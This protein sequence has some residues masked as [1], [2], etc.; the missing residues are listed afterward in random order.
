MTPIVATLFPRLSAYEL[1]LTADDPGVSMALEHWP[2]RG[3]GGAVAAVRHVGESPLATV[4][5][6]F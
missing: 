1:R 6:V 3:G 2:A 5:R 4:V